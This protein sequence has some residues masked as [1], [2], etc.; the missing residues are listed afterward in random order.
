MDIRN[1]G[2]RQFKEEEGG[3]IANLVNKGLEL[4]G[5]EWDFFSKIDA[6]MVLPKDYFEQIFSEF[7]SSDKLGITSS[8]C[9]T[10]DRGERL[11]KVSRII[12]EEA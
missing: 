6:D 3:Q 4:S 5:E 8:S 10:M 2:Q 7:K 1:F 9:Y 11:E 12:P